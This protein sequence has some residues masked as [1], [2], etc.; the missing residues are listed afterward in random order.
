[1]R[2][3]FTNRTNFSTMC[4]PL[5]ITVVFR[6][7]SDRETAFSGPQGFQNAAFPNLFGPENQRGTLQPAIYYCNTRGVGNML[8]YSTYDVALLPK[9]CGSNRDQLGYNLISAGFALD[10][11]VDAVNLSNDI[12]L[13]YERSANGAS[14][15]F[16]PLI[17]SLRADMDD[18]H[19]LAARLK[20]AGEPS[21]PIHFSANPFSP[22]AFKRLRWQSHADVRH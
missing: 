18:C 19:A 14:S 6:G 2:T 1:M 16:V 3:R 20:C 8:A 9:L 21:K 22:T 12:L 7:G 10:A 11:Y 17:A 4:N 13:Q 5:S 15:T